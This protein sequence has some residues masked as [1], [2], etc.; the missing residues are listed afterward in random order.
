MQD[1]AI[2]LILDIKS[3]LPEA[4]N[5]EIARVIAPDLGINDDEGIE[6]LATEIDGIDVEANK[7]K[8]SSDL[9]Q[10]QTEG[11]TG[12]ASTV[13]GSDFL[14][15]K[16]KI[17]PLA[18]RASLL[19]PDIEA[20]NKVI[21]DRIHE[22]ISSAESKEGAASAISQLEQQFRFNLGEDEKQNILDLSKQS[23]SNRAEARGARISS[24]AF[25]QNEK[26][27]NALL[28]ESPENEKEAVRDAYYRAQD[29]RAKH[30]EFN[31]QIS[32]MVD[33]GLV[34][35]KW[36]ARAIARNAEI[37]RQLKEVETQVEQQV[38]RDNFDGA[39]EAV[40]L[41]NDIKGINRKQ[42]KELAAAMVS[43]ISKIEVHSQISDSFGRLRLD[44][45]KAIASTYSA[46][47]GREMSF[48]EVLGEADKFKATIPTI[49]S[50]AVMAAAARSSLSIPSDE[51][52]AEL[53]ERMN[54]AK[55]EYESIDEPL[56][57]PAATP[58]YEFAGFQ[59]ESPYE[60]AR[61]R[62]EEAK[63]E[64]AAFRV[65]KEK[66]TDFSNDPENAMAVSAANIYEMLLPLQMAQSSDMAQIMRSKDPIRAAFELS[67][68]Y[69]AVANESGAT[70][71]AA[72][73]DWVQEFVSNNEKEIRESMVSAL[74]SRFGTV[75]KAKLEDTEAR[76]KSI[77]VEIDLTGDGAFGA[78]IGLIRTL[79]GN[80]ALNGAMVANI[81]AVD[82]F[83]SSF[84]AKPTAYFGAAT[85]DLFNNLGTLVKDVFTGRP[86][87]KEYE[88]RFS[89]QSNVERASGMF[90][91]HRWGEDV[92]GTTSEAL[93][94]AAQS[95]PYMLG[96]IGATAL[97]RNPNA[98][99]A[100]MALMEA[101]NMNSMFRKM[102][103]FYSLSSAE[104]V[105]SISAGAV[106]AAGLERV[107]GDIFLAN[108]VLGG[109]FVRAITESPMQYG[110]RIA[111][112][113]GLN[114]T[115]EQLTEVGTA[116][117]QN[118]ITA[119][120]T[121]DYSWFL[122]P[123]RMVEEI[124]QIGASTFL[125]S[126]G[127]QAIA[128]AKGNRGY[129][130]TIEESKMDLNRIF[131]NTKPN[132]PERTA[133]IDEFIKSFNNTRYILEDNKN[134]Y[135]FVSATNQADFNRINAI[136]NELAILEGELRSSPTNTELGQTIRDKYNELAAIE[137][138]YTEQFMFSLGAEGIDTAIAS[139]NRLM[140]RERSRKR[141]LEKSF[142]GPTDPTNAARIKESEIE[143]ARLKEKSNL[144]NQRKAEIQANT[145]WSVFTPSAE[146]SQRVP[147]VQVESMKSAGYRVVGY[148][149][150][151]AAEVIYDPLGKVRI[152]NSLPLEERVRDSKSQAD[153]ISMRS[154]GASN[155]AV[156]S[157]I[158]KSVADSLITNQTLT[159]YQAN[160]YNKNKDRVDQYVDN[161]RSNYSSIQ[162]RVLESEPATDVS[163]SVRE[164]LPSGISELAIDAL[165]FAAEKLGIKIY[166]AKDQYSLVKSLV[167]A[168]ESIS[169]ATDVLKTGR[170][171]GGSY[172]KGAIYLTEN[173]KTKD[174]IEEVIH[175]FFDSDTAVKS[176]L[177]RKIH[178]EFSKQASYRSIM[179]RK[180]FVYQKV[181]FEGLSL[182]EEQVAE[183][184]ARALSNPSLEVS[185][186]II[187]VAYDYIVNAFKSAFGLSNSDMNGLNP[188]KIVK[189]F[190]DSI[191]MNKGMSAK[192]IAKVLNAEDSYVDNEEVNSIDD[193]KF[194]FRGEKSFLYNKTVEYQELFTN[195]QG[196]T[197]RVKEHKKTFN[198]YAHFRNWYNYMTN[199]GRDKV[200][201]GFFYVDDQGNRKELRPP[202][203]EVNRQTGE[204][205]GREKYNRPISYDAKELDRRVK[206]QK[207]RDQLRRNWIVVSN[208]IKEFISAKY[209]GFGSGTALQ[210]YGLENADMYGYVNT[211]Y[212]RVME[213]S[214]EH[215]QYAYELLDEYIQERDGME[216]ERAMFSIDSVPAQSEMEF[217]N[218]FK[219]LAEALKSASS[220][221][222]DYIKTD[223]YALLR[224]IDVPED[225]AME[226]ASGNRREDIVDFIYAKS[227]LHFA[228]RI[229]PLMTFTDRAK[230]ILS[231]RASNSIKATFDER[232]E[233]GEL[234]SLRF[235]EATDQGIREFLADSDPIDFGGDAGMEWA[236]NNVNLFKCIIAITSN[237]NTSND[238]AALAKYIMMALA[239]N[240]SQDGTINSKKKTIK[241]LVNK[242]SNSNAF[243]GIGV[244][245]A[246]A[247]SIGIQL[248][249]FLKNIEGNEVGGSHDQFLYDLAMKQGKEKAWATSAL[250]DMI[251]PKIGAWAS[252]MIGNQDVVTQDAHLVQLI[253]IFRGAKRK[254]V[255]W[256]GLVKIL[257]K[258]YYD[259]LENSQKRITVVG[260]IIRRSCYKDH[261]GFDLGLTK[262]NIKALNKWFNKNKKDLLPTKPKN[263]K[264][265]EFI[266]GLVTNMAK[267]LSNDYGVKITPAVAQQ[268]LFQLN[269]EQRHAAGVSRS[270]YQTYYESITSV[271][272]TEKG[273][274]AFDALLNPMLASDAVTRQIE[275]DEAFRVSEDGRAMFSIVPGE[276]RTHLEEDFISP[277]GEVLNSENLQDVLAPYPLHTVIM[278]Q[279]TTPKD[280]QKVFAYVDQRIMS[281]TLHPVINVSK[282][283]SGQPVYVTSETVLTDVKF[284]KPSAFNM[285]GIAANNAGPKKHVSGRFKQVQENDDIMTGVLIEM[286][287]LRNN[288]FADENGRLIKSA[289]EVTFIGG[290]MIARG[291]I[292]YYPDS[293][294][295]NGLS[296]AETTASASSR[297]QA[298]NEAII[299]AVRENLR[300]YMPEAY[301][302]DEDA[303]LEIY[304]SLT[305][306]NQQ[307]IMVNP[308]N[309]KGRLR[310][311]AERAAASEDFYEI[312][313]D[314]LDNPNNYLETQHLDTAK[315][316]LRG[317]SIQ[318]LVSMMRGDKLGSLMNRNDDLG[319]L[320]GIEII[321]RMQAEGRVDAIPSV[322]EDLAKMGTSVGRLLRQFAELK[323]STSFGLYSM[324]AKLAESQ[325]KVLNE[326]QKSDLQ[327]AADA[328]MD[329]YREYQALL[330]RA[331]AG[332]DVEAELKEATK[333][334]S[335]AQAQL[336]TL[337]NVFV[338]K[339]WADIGIQLMQG[340]LLTSMSQAKNIAY[341]IAQMFPRT[342]VDLTSYPVEKLLGLMGMK[343]SGRRVSMAAY[344]HGLKKFG[345]GWVEAIEQVATGRSKEVN[346]WRMDRG[347]MPVRSLIAALSNDLPQT[348]N[349][350][351]QLNSRMKLLVAG[352]FGIPAETM[353][354]FLSLGDIPFRRFAEATELYHLGLGKGLKGAELARFL[355][356]PD[357]ASMDK[358][359]DEG[360]RM[361]FQKEGGLA[362]GSMWIISNISRGL[363]KMFENNKGFDAPGFFRFFIR[364]NV[365]YVT[366]IANF[367]E[368]SL[369]YISPAFGTA[370]VASNMLNNNAEE[371]AKNATKVMV[372]QVFTQ[373]ALYMIAG[374]VL[375]GAVDWEDDEKTNIMYD[376]MPPNSINISALKRLMNGEDPTP[377]EG[378]VYKSYQTFGVLG[379]IMGAYA[380][381]MTKE[382]AQ[383]A[384]SNPTKGIN[385]LKRFLGM[386]NASL[387]SYMMDQSFMQGLNGMLEVIT[388][389][390]PEKL[391]M[392]MERYAESLSKAY[393]AMAIP[394]F[395]SGLNM[396]TREFLPD[397]RDQDLTDRIFN[398]VKERTFNTDGLPVKVNWKGERIDQAPKGGNQFAYYMFDPYKTT[399]TGSDPVSIEILG[400]YTR[401]GE[402]PKAV[403][404]PYYASSVHR[405]LEVPSLK[406][407]KSRV[408]L[409]KLK[410]RG[411]SY[412]FLGKTGEDFRFSL[413]AEELNDMLEMSNSHRYAHIQEF[414]KRP[415]YQNMSDA[416]KIDALNEINAKYNS[417]IEYYPDGTFM[418]H[419]VYVLDVIQQRYQEL[420][421]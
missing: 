64:L 259:L 137:D 200:V 283:L 234:E 221:A 170:E 379:S 254:K 298:Q 42:K 223:M 129:V 98:G 286:D 340:N 115:T 15:P 225:V 76:L 267:S 150:S 124:T 296:A 327:V 35:N 386:E 145:G 172:Y 153:V 119:N 226:Y 279:G 339:T 69:T 216:A 353:F 3:Q 34:T 358:A 326:E 148:N 201:V 293:M 374:G 235:F 147:A 48:E 229:T 123:S 362:R 332:E 391:E 344:L 167:E 375:S 270:N 61:L 95:F 66:M 86:D 18:E 164:G 163:G 243:A 74:Q 377:Q 10:G 133:A 372:G 72:M 305:P 17:K 51:Y 231:Q 239:R 12:L 376:V 361:T 331:I 244:N 338:D 309:K 32:A 37:E 93:S 359:A 43:G 203:P 141:R 177:V 251:S 248:S 5:K 67:G 206:D 322:I 227:T 295:K 384:I 247:K 382:A 135:D 335:D 402:L 178:S 287:P 109:T 104:K 175:A 139:N 412:S 70:K 404:T 47:T 396:A 128:V 138:K 102:P 31:D 143:I 314:I 350:R 290:K 90:K 417:M 311:T 318:E 281:E 166:Y 88:E 191:I 261:E 317:K 105:A 38:N 73:E 297:T 394:N 347:F 397:K 83:L 131:Q 8:E 156:D 23:I 301:T 125:V 215:I 390:D 348:R 214:L 197:T 258:D 30:R 181:G 192:D 188:E 2:R 151:G 14:S 355:K 71:A 114:L 403:G 217:R 209:G 85:I 57:T 323:T 381:S 324:I 269:H 60:D 321:N 302:E 291:N 292:E 152:D 121:G 312:K 418:P 106:L 46:R 242:I 169:A 373:G 266:A 349:G 184:L 245:P 252:N 264:E 341:N 9:N 406:D 198:D 307:A 195:K 367:M 4:S 218:K 388:E 325:G 249:K 228:K 392:A 96:A 222:K 236:K 26:E 62:F 316:E 212:G 117:G 405:K 273:L 265:R 44:D 56:F 284:P 155:S 183:I 343:T 389:S 268:M 113:I 366:T 52:E 36:A 190:S 40:K 414:M 337:T 370:R 130:R 142:G 250:M 136:Q 158:M 78:N 41:I 368:E 77:G 328:F 16:P 110:A 94:M 27:L 294:N 213:G 182:V 398:H 116:F 357:R 278:N 310:G 199:N 11:P 68:A 154:R 107:G 306:E 189:I 345:S 351:Q 408:A 210:S 80:M 180:K 246:R 79:S 55:K 202:A 21:S 24:A 89:V 120:V 97:T 49:I 253:N 63:A 1:K 176:R 329:S 399:T 240:I 276:S 157:A 255:D 415:E 159:P 53:F 160:Y 149:E 387:I 230:S 75:D 165:Q 168:G 45:A 271:S 395:F 194:S 112:Q 84:I 82:E 29:V 334:Y 262:D 111:G 162:S 282:T 7:K 369:T 401:T 419:S 409:D 410:E 364:S 275:S 204:V 237:G 20:T 346:E 108:K 280:G 238:N 260:Q 232:I 91:S 365:P 100:V 263:K 185:R 274:S 171:I 179:N 256:N 304:D 144:L 378:D 174:V 19:N 173:S 413:T 92:Y 383:D 285:A 65:N 196:V 299:E 380:Q 421:P 416:E 313:N 211:P 320:A 58:T 6:S 420:Q 118:L 186:N 208:G 288:G 224:S 363:G 207:N 303:L 50:D 277:N 315:E 319:V 28:E 103:E 333:K 257:G 219:S 39:L 220:V 87:L 193:P 161:Q 122:S 289:D 25:A 342:M 356:Y 126:G 134:F 352:T 407:K 22:I 336:D 371:A 300:K 385:V 360:A 140:E 411:K 54:E 59:N 241:G 132:T 330:D 308:A 233:S 393:S 187:L 81:S 99:M 400:I 127:V 272:T 146:I 101:G 33:Q 354:R 13:L 205:Y